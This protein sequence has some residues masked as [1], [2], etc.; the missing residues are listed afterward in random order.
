MKAL[1]RDRNRLEKRAERGNDGV[2][3]G[4]IEIR[5]IPGLM[6]DG[7]GQG[8]PGDCW[9]PWYDGGCRVRGKNKSR[10][11]HAAG[12]GAAVGRAVL[13]T[14]GVHMQPRACRCDVFA[15]AGIVNVMVERQ[16]RLSLSAL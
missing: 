9:Q 6:A 7:G 1:K 8:S 16:R 13:Y 2:G 11:K 5:A 10:G 15:G 3:I 14:A 4:M 12:L